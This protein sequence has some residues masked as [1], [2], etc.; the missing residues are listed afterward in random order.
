MSVQRA[1][2]NYPCL[3]ALAKAKSAKERK[4]ILATSAKCIYAIIFDIAKQVMKGVIPINQRHK[5]KLRR[6]KKQLRMLTNKTSIA[7]KKKIVNQKGGFLPL[8]IKPA[9]TVL[10]ACEQTF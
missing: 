6:Y 2:K 9:L 5:F 10:A 1:I 8:L 3:Q 4:K 7:N